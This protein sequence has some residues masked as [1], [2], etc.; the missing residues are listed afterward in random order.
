MFNVPDSTNNFL[1]RTLT[2]EN[3]YEQFFNEIVDNKFP[4]MDQQRYHLKDQ[5]QQSF[6]ANSDACDQNFV[7]Y[8]I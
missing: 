8:S 6:G 7:T 4:G 5:C 2:F 1:N 3:T